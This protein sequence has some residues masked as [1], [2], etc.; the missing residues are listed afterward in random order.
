MAEPG[1][2][3]QNEGGPQGSI[4]TQLQCSVTS[5]DDEVR[6]LLEEKLARK[7]DGYIVLFNNTEVKN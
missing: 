4:T 3:M 2:E 6:K 5:S 7:L 1:N